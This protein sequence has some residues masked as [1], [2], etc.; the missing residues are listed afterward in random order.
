MKAQYNNKS[1][2]EIAKHNKNSASADSEQ[3]KH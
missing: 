1:L 2:H 3:N